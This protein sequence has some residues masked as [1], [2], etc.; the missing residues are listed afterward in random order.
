M[1]DL[2]WRNQQQAVLFFDERVIHDAY[3]LP[4]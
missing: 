1:P 2:A 3:E 4:R